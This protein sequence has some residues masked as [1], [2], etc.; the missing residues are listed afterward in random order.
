MQKFDPTFDLQELHYE[1]QE[2]F[3]EFFCNY[4]EGNLEYIEKVCGEAGLAVAKS[5]IKL[6]N[7]EGWQYKYTDILD[8]GQANFLGAQVGER[9]LAAFSFTIQVQEIDCRVDVK[10]PEVIKG[11]D[12]N[13]ILSSTYRIVLSKHGEPDIAV[14]GHYWEI[15]EFQKLGEVAQIV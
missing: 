13:K 3:K 4:L 1:A 12:E 9:G 7:T 15:V 10:K 8:C 2:I 11:G 5:Q 14:T 6:R